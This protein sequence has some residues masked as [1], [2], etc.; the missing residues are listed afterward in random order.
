MKYKS[1]HQATIQL[2][3]GPHDEHDQ[4]KLQK[5]MGFNYR[6]AIGKLIY[7]LT[8]CRIDVSI[9]VIT[10]SQFSSNPAQVHYNAIKEVFLYLYATQ[11]EGLTYW[12]PTPDVVST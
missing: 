6:Q 10:L 8:V 5:K 4:C 1:K 3:T 11:Y 9:A 7:A 2:S 12:R